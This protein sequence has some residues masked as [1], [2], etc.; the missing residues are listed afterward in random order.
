MPEH[1][2]FWRETL[3]MIELI[4]VAALAIGAALFWALLDSMRG[5]A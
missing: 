4:L 1:G 3:G 2:P 5:E